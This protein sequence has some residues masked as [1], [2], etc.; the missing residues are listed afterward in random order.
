MYG[1][2]LEEEEARLQG[3]NAELSDIQARLAV[4]IPQIPIRTEADAA[5][6]ADGRNLSNY[7]EEN[8]D[9]GEAH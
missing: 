8:T 3:I 5:I 1:F 6:G 2:S 7:I 9:V 4:P